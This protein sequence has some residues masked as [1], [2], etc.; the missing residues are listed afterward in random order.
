MVCGTSA[1]RAAGGN[2]EWSLTAPGV[3][4]RSSV[5]PPKEGGGGADI[6]LVPHLR[7]SS[8]CTCPNPFCTDVLPR[9]QRKPTCMGRR[10]HRASELEGG[11]LEIQPP[12]FANQGPQI[13]EGR[14]FSQNPTARKLASGCWQSQSSVPSV[15]SQPG[16]ICSGPCGMN[17]L[18]CPTYASSLGLCTPAL[19]QS[20]LHSTTRVIF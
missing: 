18:L 5:L 1:E 12:P 9:G 4:Q 10:S 6:S 8:I 7:T 15:F 14:L 11:T 13:R 16:L 19:S 2:K 17:G 20:V 3:P